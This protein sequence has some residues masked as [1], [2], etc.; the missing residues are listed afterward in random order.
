MSIE[1]V[2][3]RLTRTPVKAAWTGPGLSSE[4]LN[5]VY[6]LSTSLVWLEYSSLKQAKLEG[7]GV[8]RGSAMIEVMMAG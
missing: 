5:L 8:K 4:M 1:R 6:P 2:L 3:W 7:G